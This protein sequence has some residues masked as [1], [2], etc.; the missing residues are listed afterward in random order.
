MKKDELRDILRNWAILEGIIC[1]QDKDDIKINMTIN[2]KEVDFFQ[3]VNDC[4][5]C[6][7]DN[8]DEES[9]GGSWD[10]SWDDSWDDSW[11][12]L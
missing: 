7:P 3:I 2:D 10:N 11:E 1:D 12:E 9:W 8:E 6:L 5:S 4:V